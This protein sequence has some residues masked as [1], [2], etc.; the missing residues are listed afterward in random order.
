MHEHHDHKKHK[1]SHEEVIK[2]KAIITTL[3]SIPVVLL[4]VKEF[5][6]G[7]TLNLL[8]STFIYLYG[9]TFFLK[10]FLEEI[11]KRKP[12]MMTLVSLGIS[13]AYFYS[14]YTYFFGG[15]SFFWELSTLIAVMLWGHWIEMRS[16]AGAGKA[17]EELVKLIPSKAH[18]IR[19]G[20]TVEV[21]THS[22]KPGDLVLVK[23]GERIPADGVVEEGESFV[24]ESVL[25]GESKPVKKGKGDKLIGGSLNLDGF[26]KVRVEKAGR[27]TYLSQ[28]MKLI[29]EAQETKTKLQNI[30]DRAA[31]YL[32]VIAVLSGFSSL[33]AW[34]YLRGDT[35]FAVE[36]A[37]TVMVIACPHAL[38]LAIPLVVAISTA[39]SARKGILI[40][41]RVALERA[42]DVEVVVF[43]KTGTLTEGRLSVSDVMT[44][45][46]ENE[47]LKLVAS[48]E[49]LSEHHL[50][51]AVVN[52]AKEKGVNLLEVSEFK[53]FPGKGV[54]GKVN[55]KEVLVGNL[56][57]LKEKGVKISEELLKRCE[58]LSLAGKSVIYASF[59][60]VLSG[61]VALSDRIRKESYEA[62]RL[63]KEMGKK[64]VMITGDDEK[65][66]K[67]VSEELGIEEFFARVLPHEKALKVKELQERGY[68]VAMVGDG[69]NDAPALVQADVGIAIGSGT[70]IAIESA[71]IILVKSNP[72][73]VV[74]V[75]RLSEITVKKMYQNLFW[76]LSYNVVAIPL[77]MGLGVPFGIVLKPAVGAILMSASTVIVSLNAL[78]MKRELV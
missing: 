28:V 71:D 31:F 42:K 54:Y 74:E 68:M 52:Y 23:P 19:D 62:V 22:L 64:V 16:I 17:L 36:R 12:G 72:L 15:K 53:A 6:Y 38:G 13:V 45:M 8:L 69:V 49:A 39:Y 33:I 1:E 73:D 66:A 7:S 25:T 4:S 77:A 63:L 2:R 75:F 32:T 34:I 21:P 9:G 26:L 55:G 18:L 5:P 50:G 47:F 59:D 11:K 48:V 60:G 57:F 41:N 70:D 46:E 14:V 20:E 78:L 24:D 10:G 27:D 61:C 35:T 67:A 44:D 56:E 37:V 3:L 40:R 29:K 51:R 43:D 76:A 30:A 58:E 65:V